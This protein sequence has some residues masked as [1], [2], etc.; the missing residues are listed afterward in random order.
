M[1]LSGAFH[2]FWIELAR[3]IPLRGEKNPEFYRSY[4]IVLG[5]HGC[6][7]RSDVTSFIQLEREQW[8]KAVNVAALRVLEV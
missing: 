7:K 2:T 4:I 8:K 1:I 6:W 3:R 5:T